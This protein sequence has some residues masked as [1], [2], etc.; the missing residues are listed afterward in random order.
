MPKSL[1]SWFYYLQKERERQMVRAFVVV[2]LG[3]FFFFLVC[4]FKV[5]ASLWNCGDSREKSCI[6]CHENLARW[7]V[8]YIHGV[9]HPDSTVWH[10][11]PS[12]L[13]LADIFFI[14]QDSPT[15]PTSR[16][17]WYII[18]KLLVV[19]PGQEDLQDP[20]VWNGVLKLHPFH[21]AQCP[22]DLW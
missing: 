16:Y 21:P 7:T 14:S 22:L 19:W 5:N 18:L 9:A 10:I 4:F 17:S 15:G 1:P 8:F 13:H 12:F 3:F 6:S 2:V 20:V 11:F